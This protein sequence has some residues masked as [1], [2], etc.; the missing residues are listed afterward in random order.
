MRTRLLIALLAFT[1]ASAAT[2]QARVSLTP[3]SAPLLWAAGSIPLIYPTDT[4][5]ATTGAGP[6]TW[7][8]AGIG[9]IG[10]YSLARFCGI[11]E[12]SCAGVE[13]LGMALG[14]FTGAMIGSA[15]EGDQHHKTP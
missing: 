15:I 1:V 3:H 13:L 7:I 10:G 8:G 2:A 4:V 11:G 14:A 9:A 6:G 12:G 5:R